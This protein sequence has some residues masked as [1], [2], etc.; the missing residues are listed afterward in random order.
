MTNTNIFR[1]RGFASLFSIKLVLL[2]SRV[3]P[4]CSLVYIDHNT[5]LRFQILTMGRDCE[6]Y[7][8]PDSAPC[9]TDEFY[10]YFG[11]K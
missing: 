9:T 11:G 3:N 4:S 10:R 5:A 1:S 6:K 8:L 7:H 2:S